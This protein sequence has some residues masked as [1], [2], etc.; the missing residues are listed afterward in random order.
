MTGE[1]L[2]VRLT[3]EGLQLKDV[4]HLL[5]MS[6]QNFSALLKVKDVKSG[7]IEKIA[8]ALGK[9]MTFFYPTPNTTNTIV[10]N[11][12][13]EQNGSAVAENNST[14]SIGADPTLVSQLLQEL[15]EMRKVNQ[16][17]THRLLEK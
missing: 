11:Y 3:K 8:E 13:K 17:L 16:D 6:Q 12:H 1:Q 2:K 5:S 14:A 10:N 15:S 4:A 7:T 9:D